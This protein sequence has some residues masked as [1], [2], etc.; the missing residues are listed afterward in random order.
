MLTKLID[1]C[2]QYRPV[3]LLGAVILCVL[4]IA[5]FRDLPFDAFPD[6]TPVQVQVNTTAPALSNRSG[7][8]H[9]LHTLAC[10]HSRDVLSLCLN[11]LKLSWNCYWSSSR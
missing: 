10:N 3:V 4:G 8:C 9:C 6:T 7:P 2:L 1:L 11:W 5:S